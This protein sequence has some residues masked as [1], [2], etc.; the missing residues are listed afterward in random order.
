MFTI[1][2]IDES[3]DNENSKSDNEEVDN[4]LEEVA[5]GDMSDRV[6][7]KDIR[8][9]KRK[10]GK[11]ESAGEETS[12]GHNHVIYK[13]FNNGGKSATNSDTDGEVHNI[14]AVDEFTEFFHEGA[15]G[16]F[17]DRVRISHGVIIT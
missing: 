2:A 12:D 15:F 1:H 14:T 13:R 3:D 10:G 16:D 17:F 5:V 8:D 7:S 11:I 9:V 6:G 4:V